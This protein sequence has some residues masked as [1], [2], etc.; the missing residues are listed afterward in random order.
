M[1]EEATAA[2]GPWYLAAVQSNPQTLA[3]ADQ[4]KFYRVRQ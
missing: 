4:M 1:L 3:A 2:K